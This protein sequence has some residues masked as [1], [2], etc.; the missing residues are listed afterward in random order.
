M[1]LLN[2]VWG[3]FVLLAFVGGWQIN[4]V[5]SEPLTVEKRVIKEVIKEVKVPVKEIVEVPVKENPS[6]ATE[7]REK[8][9]PFDWIKEDQIHVYPDK[10][11]IDV[12][13]A[14]WA[15]FVDTNSMDPV[16]DAGANALQF[17]PKSTNDIHVGDIVSY[18]SEY[19][20]GTFIHRVI[21]VNYDDKGWYA[22]LKGDNNKTADPGKI[23][24]NQIKKVLFGVIY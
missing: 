2:V 22:I 24:F 21:D 10:I 1:K 16:F 7:E 11:V 23:R 19:A 3:V 18:E 4:N 20:S 12:N 8:P 13:D 9:S 17:I 5:L 14:R 15:K 6:E